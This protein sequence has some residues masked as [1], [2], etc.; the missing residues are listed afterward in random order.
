VVTAAGAGLSGLV[1][2]AQLVTVDRTTSV[3]DLV[4][5][6]C[7]SFAG[8][9]LGLAAYRLVSDFPG[10]RGLQDFLREPPVFL[11]VV[12]VAVVMVGS[13]NPFDFSLDVGQLTST[14]RN[15]IST[16]LVTSEPLSDELI[17]G[18]RFMILAA[19]STFWLRSMGIPHYLLGGLLSSS[20]IG[21]FLE[22][23]Q[24][25]VQSRSPSLWD[26][27]VVVTAC[28]LGTFSMVFQRYPLNTDRIPI[29]WII[30]IVLVTLVGATIRALSPFDLSYSYNAINWIPFRAYYDY[31]NAIALSNFIESTLTY[32]PMV[33]M[34]QVIYRGRGLNLFACLFCL[35]FA[36]GLESAQGWIV[37]RYPDITDA[38][39]AF[40]GTLAAA[41][42]GLQFRRLLDNRTVTVR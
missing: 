2:A 24:F 9:V 16:P 4:T 36:L 39:G 33:F 10:P 8:A 26:A 29:A 34:L 42:A 30:G 37:G 32:I 11:G 17:V 35:L 28:S 7:G 18:L 23:A 22:T 3:T 25:L 41:R 40:I 5:N 31:T 19:V 13:L 27:A 14:A 38:L 21:L 6:T 1:E 15:L 20:F 12:T